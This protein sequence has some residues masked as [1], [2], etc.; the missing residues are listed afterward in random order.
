MALL[1]AESNSFR[2]KNGILEILLLTICLFINI[3]SQRGLLCQHFKIDD[4]LS[5][6]N[7]LIVFFK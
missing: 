2:K 3:R 1:Y 4:I 6:N 5:N 7:D